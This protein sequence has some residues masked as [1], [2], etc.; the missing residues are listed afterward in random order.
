MNTVQA[1]APH[2]SIIFA[3]GAFCFQRSF[4]ICPTQILP[5]CSNYV[6]NLLA[7]QCRRTSPPIVAVIRPKWSS[8]VSPSPS[9]FGTTGISAPQALSGL[10]A[11]GSG[12]GRHSSYQRGQ[13]APAASSPNDA[14][15]FSSD[16][17]MDTN[18]DMK[19]LLYRILSISFGICG[20]ALA[21]F[22]TLVIEHLFSATPTL[23]VS[24]L[25]HLQG[26][27]FILISIGCSCLRDA[28]AHARL[29]S[30][31]YKRLNKGLSV[32]GFASLIAFYTPPFTPT[33]TITIAARF[34]CTTLFGAAA[35]LPLLSKN[36]YEAPPAPSRPLWPFIAA[37]RLYA[38]A[39]ST[40]LF[41]TV[42]I[43]ISFFRPDWVAVTWLTAPLGV[44]GS[45]FLKLLGCGA[46]FATIVLE[47]LKD[48]ARRGRLGASTF[49]KLN[50]GV[51]ILS[52]M[53]IST[54]YYGSVA[55][56]VN[57]RNMFLGEVGS[58][59]NVVRHTVTN[60]F[61][62][63]GDDFSATTLAVLAILAVSS[64]CSAFFAKKK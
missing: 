17:L 2:R 20:A 28:A 45:L 48:A 32:W 52:A 10:R 58:S 16:D 31:T 7:A 4:Q 34:L 57:L 42:F 37:G 39:E 59:G 56:F 8:S 29:S 1:R 33:I 23:L 51:G 27:V 61:N 14:V 22:P 53:I 49:K 47:N 3:S 54:A 62:R 15:S 9:S 12:G 46:S 60:M 38:I 26:G 21:Y 13:L 5:A 18:N 55:G 11:P 40:A 24:R 64:L 43:F 41:V 35:L 30:D 63:V 44:L 6:I 50:L 19:A 36:T 25:A